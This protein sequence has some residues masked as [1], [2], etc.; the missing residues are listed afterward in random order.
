MRRFL[1]LLPPMVA[2]CGDDDGGNQAVPAATDPAAR[3]AA[4]DDRPGFALLED[5]DTLAVERYSRTGNTL[6]GEL[7]D[8][9]EGARLTYAATL[10]PEE[11]ITRI[12][13]TFFPAGADQPRQRAVGEF[14]G[15]TLVAETRREE[16]E[17]EV[18]RVHTPAGTMLVV[19]NSIAALEQLVRRAR[20]R[21]DGPVEVPVLVI[22]GNGDDRQVIERARITPLG[23]DSVHLVLDADNQLRVAVDGGGMIQGGAHPE[24]NVRVVRLR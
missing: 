13:L 11:R 5:G 16:G 8:V 17:P 2:A 24:R 6:E 14:R 20:S 19:A 22:G 21:G 10:G 3:S 7:V 12:E 4:A 23:A 18:E 15:D 1:A 9:R